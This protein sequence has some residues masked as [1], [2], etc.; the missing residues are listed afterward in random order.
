MFESQMTF[1]GYWLPKE[2][3]ER[4][5][6]GAT[7]ETSW[8]KGGMLTT[9][10]DPDAVAVRW[11]RLAA[12]QWRVLL[13]GL[14]QARTV[15][16][17]EVLARWQA[18]LQVA[19]AQ[20]VEHTA[21]MMSALST[22]TGYSPPMLAM[23]LGLGDLISPGSLSAALEFQPTWSAATRWEQM[24]DLPGRVRFFPQRA[25]DRAIAS[26]RSRSPLC[27]PAPPL[28]LALGYAAGNVPGTALLIALLGGL[29][30]YASGNGMPVPAVLIRN[31][32]HEPL[33]AP[34]VLSVVEAI[35]PALVAGLAVLIWDYED[36]S[37]QRELMRRAGLMIAAA[38]DDTIAALE[39]V[40]AKS[41][42]T[43]RFHRHGH[44][45]S[46]AV[47]GGRKSEVGGQRSEIRTLRAK[48]EIALLAAL[49]S[50]LWDQNGCLSARAHFVAGDADGYA[51][52][53][54]EQ[55]RALS[56]LL[57]RGTT[58]RRLTH[59]AFDT[60]A[61]LAGSGQVRVCSTYDDDFAVIVD[62]RTWNAETL[63]RTVNACQG[64][65]IVVRPV[66]DVMDVPG[67]LRWLPPAN[68]QSVSVA[69]DEARVPE[70]AEAVGARGVTAVRSLGRAA[71]PQ[72]AY[73]WDGLLPL[74]VGHLRPEGHFTTIEFDDLQQ[75][76]D[77]TAGR[78]RP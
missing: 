62:A 21:E 77:E 6:D 58:P 13:E 55:M 74:D 5:L 53:L 20:L 9:P 22:C 25:P 39:A 7:W 63:R 26:L 8:L 64:R 73:S 71:F 41:T 43:L 45:V 18:V 15:G 29:A 50:S 34:W 54:V 49:D 36:E 14:Q 60:Y 51:G 2:L 3:R 40:R 72:L 69:M 68:L 57:P 35:D 66:E 23:A 42:P 47:I 16:G 61:A 31:S 70:F 76:L 52:A 17:R 48:S 11:P 28:D 30:N 27:R 19:R 32:R 1:E 59:R 67:V 78:W 33:F 65:V 24:P 4:V 37:R 56:Q 10:D 38:G 44:K 75:E 12:E 46:F